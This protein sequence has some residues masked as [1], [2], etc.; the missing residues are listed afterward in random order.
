MPFK[1]FIQRFIEVSLTL[2]PSHVLLAL[3]ICFYWTRTPRPG[4]IMSSSFFKMS[5]IGTHWPPAVHCTVLPSPPL[6]SPQFWQTQMSSLVKYLI[7][8]PGVIVRG[9]SRVSP[10]Y[11]ATQPHPRVLV[12]GSLPHL[13]FCFVFLFVHCPELSFRASW[14]LCQL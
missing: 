9:C 3:F 5:F 11:R 1:D 4:Q 8:S 12:F 13:F 7:P 2:N 10:F 6:V 14:V